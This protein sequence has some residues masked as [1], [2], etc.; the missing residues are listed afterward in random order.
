[1]Q[2]GDF[3]FVFNTY[4]RQPST[5]GEFLDAWRAEEI[6]GENRVSWVLQTWRGSKK[7]TVNKKLLAAG[8]LEMVK[9]TTEEIELEWW[10][11]RNQ[12]AIAGIVQT[13]PASKLLEIASA[14]GYEH[15]P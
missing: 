14:I 4:G 5:K 6:V 12:F 1:M 11:R 2:V 9:M 10:K 15:M 8:K 13:L 3:I 7:R